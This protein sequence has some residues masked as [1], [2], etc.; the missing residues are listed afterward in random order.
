MNAIDCPVP[1][2]TGLGGSDA[3]KVLGVSRFGTRYE[4]WLEK[5]RQSAKKLET[6]PMRWGKLLEDAVAREAGR[7]LE[8]QMRQ[9]PKRCT[10]DRHGYV[11]P[12]L[13]FACAHPDRLFVP[14]VRQPAD[15]TQGAEIKTAS[16]FLAGDFGEEGTDE[17]PDDYLAQV[18]HYAMVT[19]WKV[20]HLAVLMGGQYLRTYRIEAD[21]QLHDAMRE[22]YRRFW[23]LVETRTAPEI[24]GSPGA[25][26]YLRERFRDTGAEVELTDNMELDALEYANL[27]LR[28]KEAEAERETIGNRL[29]EAMG[30]GAI[31][32]ARNVRV[33]WKDQATTSFDAKALR[34]AHPD[35]AAEFTR[36]GTTR[37]L[38]VHVR[39][40]A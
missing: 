22:E 23:H 20:W 10:P 38:R 4:L 1:R 9:P 40:A 39:E 3:A 6:E 2:H 33:T 35:I 24:D 31:A 29:R 37:V 30:D 21:P 17:V 34:E 7:K 19:G 12:V 11:D 36:K 5:T 26:E 8:G 16:Q 27:G 25:S 28:I 32:Q 15:G 18:Q 13:P 14:K